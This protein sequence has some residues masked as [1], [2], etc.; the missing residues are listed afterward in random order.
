MLQHTLDFAQ[1]FLE[2]APTPTPSVTPTGNPAGDTMIINTEGIVAAAVKFILPIFSVFI[3]FVIAGRA[4]RGRV[5]EV[6]TTSG[7]YIWGLLF[8]A[9]GPLLFVFG[10]RLVHLI[11]S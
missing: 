11:L 2:L 1:H 5:S 7:V 6:A 9:G 4:R 8:I 10:D 3:G